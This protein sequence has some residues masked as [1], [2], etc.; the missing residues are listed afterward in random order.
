MTLKSNDIELCHYDYNVSE[1]Q[2]KK[3]VFLVILADLEGVAQQP[4]TAWD[5][6]GRVNFLFAIFMKTTLI[7]SSRRCLNLH[8]KRQF[9]SLNKSGAKFQGFPLVGCCLSDALIG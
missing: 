5:A 6:F 4:L 2:K 9:I 7:I 8:F 3:W 1:N